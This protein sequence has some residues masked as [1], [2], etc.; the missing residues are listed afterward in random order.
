MA[1]WSL[2]GKESA[3][4]VLARRY[5]ASRARLLLTLRVALRFVLVLGG[6]ASLVAAAWMVAVPLGLLAGCVAMFFLEWLV[7]DG[8]R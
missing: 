3:I 6:C 2:I 7:K 4:S 1:V 5:R 8:A